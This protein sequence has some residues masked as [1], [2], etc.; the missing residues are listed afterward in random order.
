MLYM[1][2][3]IWL[4]NSKY[5]IKFIN[6]E[7]KMKILMINSVCGIKSTG[8]IC[9]DIADVLINNGH[10]CRII[11]G[12][13]SVPEKYSSISYRIASNV[14]IACNGI[15]SRIF[16]NEGFNA[17]INTKRAIKYILSY[18]PDI[19][20][21][22]N[23]HGYYLNI[24]M[25]MKFLAGL[26]IPIIYTFHDCWA[27]TGHC[28]YFSLKNCERWK[29]G[30]FKCPARKE[31]PSSILIDNS[32]R[33]YM[34][35]C[36]YFNMISNMIIITP[37]FWLSNVV[38]NSFLN[39]RIIKVIPNG[40]D[41]ELFYP[42]EST[43]REKY[44]ITDKKIILGVASTW[45]E[46]KGLFKFYELN[47]LLNDNEIIVLVGLNKKQMRTLPSKIIGIEKTNSIDELAEIY[48]SADVYV[49]LSQA[50]TMG[51][52]TVE[53]IACGTPVVVSNFTAIP[54]FINEN[55]GVIIK[56]YSSQCII[57]SIRL[58][59]SKTF[60]NVYKHAIKYEKNAQYN[61]YLSLYEDVLQNEPTYIKYNS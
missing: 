21:L 45:T 53:S 14:E 11:F 61:K 23:L 52:T 3:G 15:L 12:R 2:L 42:R 6:E 57:D 50:E 49:N 40:I 7:H 30:C 32:K 37:S 54:E 56:E 9:T 34:N 16:D 25:L 29:T 26:N 44:G 19:I 20:H 8:R 60:L 31:Y 39:N 43:F 47:D 35:K 17:K 46:L 13:E 51:L 55:C 48:S 41:L 5:L 59:F 36:K 18:K 28:S 24:S 58:V 10:E 22:H 33:N 1:K 38:Q 4:K 27:I